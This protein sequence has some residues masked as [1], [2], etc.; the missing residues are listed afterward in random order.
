MEKVPNPGLDRG[1]ALT[2]RVPAVPLTGS[3]ALDRF[4]QLLTLFLSKELSGI[5]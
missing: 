1:Q 5:I 2:V 3:D 4:I